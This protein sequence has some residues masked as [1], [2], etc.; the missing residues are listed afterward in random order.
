MQIL[1]IKN[2]SFSPLI[3]PWKSIK[4]SISYWGLGFVCV[5][6]LELLVQCENINHFIRKNILNVITKLLLT[7]CFH[8]ILLSQW[9]L[10][11]V[12]LMGFWFKASALKF[13]RCVSGHCDDRFLPQRKNSALSLR[14]TS[15]HPYVCS[16]YWYF[17]ISNKHKKLDLDLCLILL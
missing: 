9:H 3:F 10:S 4:Y 5:P 16:L 1:L 12:S 15:Y 17:I 7:I 11:Q 13:F 6:A 8:W 2:I 14:A